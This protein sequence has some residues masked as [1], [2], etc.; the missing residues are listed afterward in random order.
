MNTPPPKG[1][2]RLPKSPLSVEQALVAAD[3]HLRAGRL[4]AA[5][6]MYQEILL[7]HPHNADALHFLGVIASQEGRLE[8][9]ADLMSKAIEENRTIPFF[10]VNLGEIFRSLGRLDEAIAACRRALDL[11]PVNPDA[12][13]TL[14]AA[15]HARGDVNEAERALRRALEFKPDLAMA[16]AN[17]GNV[18]QAQGNHEEALAA[19]REA[20]RI[21]PGFAGAHAAL[22]STLQSQGQSEEAVASYRRALM[23]A[24]ND[25]AIWS[26]L[27]VAL[28]SL[29]RTD[30]AETSFRKA[31]EV[32]P[33]FA[34]GHHN[35]GMV[36]LVQG[37][38]GEAVEN[39]R[40]ALAIRRGFPPPQPATTAQSVV[41][42]HHETFRFTAE[43]KVRHDIEQ[44]EYLV[45]KGRLPASF[46]SEIDAYRAV[47]A[48]IATPKPS[49][50]V[51]AL[52]AEQRAK[53]G[54]TYNRAVCIA[55]AAAMATSPM[56][57]DL[58]VAAIEDDYYRSAPEVTFFDDFLTADALAALRRFCLESTIWYDF[59]H[60]GGYLGAYLS[61][62][63]SCGLLFQ[64]VEEL[65]KTLPRVFGD[66]KLRQMWAYKYDSSIRGI[67]THADAAAVNV[68][69]WITPD[70][71][72][73]DAES[74][75]LVVF[76][77]EAPRE[78]D[79]EKYNND[80]DSIGAFLAGSDSV[81]IPHR[82]NRVV[83]FNSNLF[84]K[85]DQFNF[86]QGYENRRINITILF[87]F[88]EGAG[89]NGGPKFDTTVIDPIGSGTP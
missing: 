31:V 30:E 34:D 71:A 62:G 13:N 47:L 86:K 80:Q 28:R 52:T 24:P 83:I 32:A 23:I 33:G 89:A 26:N 3:G 15:Y 77:R 43:H 12:L 37:K 63:F 54:R 22:G 68:N 7:R 78:W 27:G 49:S 79:F 72:N 81:A 84:H 74:G 73:L 41:R 55:E 6:A 64:I 9:A 88:R 85:S 61:D 70:E 48:E 40:T 8:R 76:K 67:P 1:A 25:A 65:R 39:Y 50:R 36:L 16:H 60:P 5:K 69:F 18:L 51:V 19:Y 58:D 44:L 59:S 57:P 38:L 46:A 11:N 29:G 20:L 14:G 2:K 53:I 75:G 42:V 10:H 4:G 21:Q 17:L 35:L 56:N 82:Q 45:A 66:H 87:G